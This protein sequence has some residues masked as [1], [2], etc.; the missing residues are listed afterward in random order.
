MHI[1][2]S[3]SKRRRMLRTKKIQVVVL[4]ICLDAPVTT[5][6]EIDLQIQMSSMFGTKSFIG[7]F[8]SIS[9]LTFVKYQILPL[10]MSSTLHFTNT[11]GHNQYNV[12]KSYIF[13][14][15]IDQQFIKVLS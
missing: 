10:S 5:T 8:G 9:F 7:I 13:L 14:F 11:S 2:S 6:Q 12:Y 4:S 3:Y 1:C 15:I